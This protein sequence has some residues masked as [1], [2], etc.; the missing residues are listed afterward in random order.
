MPFTQAAIANGLKTFASIQAPLKSGRA[1]FG[2]IA[3]Q[4][5]LGRFTG[6]KAKQ[7]LVNREPA[8]SIPVEVLSHFSYVVDLNVAKELGAYPPMLVMRFAEIVSG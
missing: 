7:I 8:A 1:L 4:Y 6:L 5:N 2:L 3:N